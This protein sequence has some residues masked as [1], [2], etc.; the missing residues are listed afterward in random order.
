M[1]VFN[2]ILNGSNEEGWTQ[3]QTIGSGSQTLLQNAE[4]YGA[5]LTTTVNDTTEPLTLAR[6]NI[7]EHLTL[8]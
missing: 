3:L 6:E 1:D 8:L 5:Y 2:N 7:G 4:R